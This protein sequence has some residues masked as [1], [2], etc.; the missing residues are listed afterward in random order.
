MRCDR[1]T[2]TTTIL[3]ALLL[4]A[5]CGKDHPAQTAP[6]YQGPATPWCQNPAEC[7]PLTVQDLWQSW[8][9]AS[10]PTYLPTLCVQVDGS[11][12]AAFAASSALTI[13]VRRNA[14]SGGPDLLGLTLWAVSGRA[15]T[16]DAAALCER[17][18]CSGG[19]TRLTVDAGRLPRAAAAPDGGAAG[20]LLSAPLD[21]TQVQVKLGVVGQGIGSILATIDGLT[22]ECKLDAQEDL[23][24]CV[25]TV[26]ACRP[27]P[28]TARTNDANGLFSS[29]INGPAMQCTTAAPANATSGTL[30]IVPGVKDDASLCGPSAVRAQFALRNYGLAVASS[31]RGRVRVRAA[32]GGPGEVLWGPEAA[33]RTLSFPANTVVQVIYEA[34]NNWEI[35]RV[36]GCDRPLSSGVC[37]LTIKPNNPPVQVA[38]RSQS[39]TLLV[40]VTGDGRVT[41]ANVNCG[42]G[43]NQCQVTQTVGS[44]V[45]LS[46]LPGAYQ[47]VRWIGAP[48]AEGQNSCVVTLDQP[49]KLAVQ[50]SPIPMDCTGDVCLDRNAGRSC[51]TPDKPYCF[52]LATTRPSGTS[53]YS[54]NPDGLLYRC[55]QRAALVPRARVAADVGRVVINANNP[56]INH[57]CGA[58][59]PQNSSLFVVGKIYPGYSDRSCFP[60]GYYGKGT[61]AGGGRGVPEGTYAVTFRGTQTLAANLWFLVMDEVKRTYINP[62]RVKYNGA[63]QTSQGLLTVLGS[64]EV[65]LEFYAPQ[66]NRLSFPVYWNNADIRFANGSI[67]PNLSL[68]VDSITIEPI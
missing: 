58:A 39:R 44:Q 12:A 17:A 57:E 25:L 60:L 65:R 24:N 48:C 67:Y 2:L 53:L 21:M 29:W 8:P 4:A 54:V 11:P 46:A 36:S 3:G 56:D 1:N 50:F 10:A 9:G 34:D 52:G 63:T 42:G 7:V 40:S 66:C 13:P 51:A 6:T 35:D 61:N 5:G 18:A 45:A 64:Y 30:N 68:S 43:G 14:A 37:E 28:L 22:H 49:V 27:L 47:R 32:N 16:A 23:K 41:G 15:G 20:W 55:D 38:F 59:S 62:S 19:G 31:G 26:P 33:A